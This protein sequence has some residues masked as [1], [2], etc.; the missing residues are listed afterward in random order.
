M[1]NLLATQL[2]LEYSLLRVA[3]RVAARFRIP[4]RTLSEL[5]RLAYFEVLRHEGLTQAEIGRRLGQTDRHMRSLAQKLRS[6][7]FAA[8]REPGVMRELETIVAEKGPLPQELAGLLPSFSE[9]ELKRAL[10]E[11][12]AEKRVA[13]GPDGRLQVGARFVQL[14]SDQFQR[15]ID[16]LNQFLDGLQQAVMH[17]LV[18]DQKQTS[19]IKTISFSANPAAV[20]AFIAQFEGTLRREV[21]TLEEQARLDPGSAH[22]FTLGLTF[23]PSTDSHLD[24]K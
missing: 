10:V 13:A 11:L 23:A 3:V 8:E 20:E 18:Y 6:D 21:A 24:D 5:L 7:F 4:M 12:L 1:A 15:R 22:Q 16:S 17:R 2:K 14:A 19:T 9:F